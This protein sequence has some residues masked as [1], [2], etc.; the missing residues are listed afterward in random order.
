MS[1]ILYDSPTTIPGKALSPNMRKTRYCLSYK[2]LPYKTHWIEYVNIQ[3]ECKKIGIPPTAKNG[4]GSDFY[5]LPAIY[6]PHTGKYIADSFEIAVYLDKTYPDALPIFPGGYQT[7]AGLQHAFEHGIFF[8]AID[9]HRSFAFYET[10]LVQNEISKP[11]FRDSFEKRLGVKLEDLAPKGELAVQ[12]WKKFEEAF[13]TVA[14][15]YAKTDAAGPYLMG[16]RISWGDIVVCSFLIWWRRLW[17]EESQQWKDIS[18]WQGGRW[19][20]LLSSLDKY[21]EIY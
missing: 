1:I 4:D 18:S 16:D 21:S 6:D 2:S 5:T 7:T 8:P 17:G 9:K 13:G 15:V 12:Q 14:A 10:F 11:Y 20:R 3:S 19:G